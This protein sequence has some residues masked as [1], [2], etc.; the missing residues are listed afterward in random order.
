MVLIFYLR[1]KMYISFSIA[2][3]LVGFCFCQALK[4]FEIGVR[5]VRCGERRGFL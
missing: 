2:T 1:N 5:V 3:F 4:N